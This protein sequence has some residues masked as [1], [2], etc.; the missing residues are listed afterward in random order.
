MKK[1]NSKLIPYIR[2]IC[3]VIAIAFIVIGIAN[4][5][6][7]TVATKATNICLECIGIG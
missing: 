4:G 2:M 1:E 5:E 6:I 7:N 3:L